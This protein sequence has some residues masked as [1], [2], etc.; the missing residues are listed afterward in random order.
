MIAESDGVFLRREALECGYSDK[1]I[2]AMLRA[3]V[4]RRVRQGAYCFTD[5]WDRLTAEGQHLV[6]AQAVLRSTPGPVAL[7][8]T[9]ALIAHGIAVWGADLS[10]VHVTRLDAGAHRV[11]RDVQHHVG[12]C[13]E[14]DVTSLGGLPVTTPWRAVIEAATVLTMEAALVSTDSALH[15]R[16]CTPDQLRRTFETLNHWPGSQHVHVVL[17]HMDGRAETPGE[18]RSRYLFWRWG[19]P[20]PVLQFEVYDATGQL[21]AV[22]D[23]AWP[24]HK[25]FGEF[26]GKVK[27]GRFLRPGETPGDAVFREKQRE[28]LVRSLT[29]FG[30][31]RLVWSDLGTGARTAARF[32][33]LL[34]LA[35]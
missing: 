15:Q 28:D 25:L 12:R 19:L 32:A 10:R 21:V 33:S 13:A 5:V 26:D 6:L 16:V 23:F 4:W 1:A 29:G 24:D 8:H 34:G 7:S 17:H 2:A 30:C 35:A 18:T 27:Y 20:R 11:E 31:G 3:G 9:T 22:T 14:T